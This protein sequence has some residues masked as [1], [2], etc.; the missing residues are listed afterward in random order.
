M[1][2]LLVSFLV[3]LLLALGVVAEVRASDDPENTLVLTLNKNRKV[4]IRLRPDLA[5]NH[6]ARIKKLARQGFF[7]NQAFHRVI[8]ALLAQGGNTADD[9]TGGTGV[10]VLAEISNESFYR[11][12]VASIRLDDKRSESNIAQFFITLQRQK[13]MDGYY[14]IWGEVIRGMRTI[15]RMKNGH[16]IISIRVAADVE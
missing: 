2:R 14:S 1:R 10:P 12:T 9:G 6:V 8:P 3:P 7:D 11:G 16:P 4:V 15:D 5:P 13:H